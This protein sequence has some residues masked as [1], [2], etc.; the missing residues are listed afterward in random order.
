LGP[1]DFEQD[2]EIR[3]RPG[4]QEQKAKGTVINAL[5]DQLGRLD[6]WAKGSM[7][8]SLGVLAHDVCVY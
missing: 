1:G 8:F 6:Y 2:T 4:I 7:E 5:E 3:F